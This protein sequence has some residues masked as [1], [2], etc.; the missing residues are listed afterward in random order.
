MCNAANIAQN[1]Y[2]W[3][4]NYFFKGEKLNSVSSDLALIEKTFL[5]FVKVTKINITV[6]QKKDKPKC[7]K[8]DYYCGVYKFSEFLCPLHGVYAAEMF[9]RWLRVMANIEICDGITEENFASY[10]SPLLQSLNNKELYFILDFSKK[11][12]SV[13]ARLVNGKWFSNLTPST[14]RQ[15]E[16]FF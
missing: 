12:A 8:V 1:V 13:Y 7:F 2:C 11:Y 4:C 9:V 10:I 14:M 15:I 16:N 6:Y 5:H 3:K